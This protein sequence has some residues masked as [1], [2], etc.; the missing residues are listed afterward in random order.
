MKIQFQRLAQILSCSLVLMASRHA[1]RAAETLDASRVREIAAQLREQ[2]AGFAWPA[3]NRAAWLRLADNPA[4][5]NVIPD[6]VALLAKKLPEQP[7]SL[8]LEYS[9]NGNRTHWQD[10]ASER[11][12]RVAKLTLA[13]AFENR[14]RFLPALETTIAALCAEKTWV[15]PAH[16]GDLK[17][18]HGEATVPDLGATSLAAE[19][20][21]ADFVLGDK[22]SPATRQLLRENVR[23]RVLDPFRAM[24]EGRQPEAFWLRATMNWNAVCVGNTVF[25]ALTLLDSR[26][27]RAFFAA[28]GE[29]CIRF[30]LSG[31]TPDGYCPEG[32][33]YW[34]YGFGHFILLT[35]ILRQST[36]GRIDLLNDD[37]A[38]A[39]A[40]F[41]LRSEVLPGI[42]PTISDC[43]PG[44]KPSARFTAYVCRRFGLDAGSSQTAG[45]EKDLTLT[46][47]LSSLDQN[48]PL[49][50]K[51]ENPSDSPL[52]SFFP[53]GGVLI[54]RNVPGAKPAF[55]AVLKGGNN[56]EPHNHNDV[57]SFSVILGREMVLCD[58]GGEVYTKRTFGAHR[59]DSKVLNSFG[60]AVPVIAGELQKAG[61]DARG[62]ILET[63]F[64]ASADT[65]KLDIR[66]AY[67]V[68]ALK[69]LDR[70]FVFQRGETPSLEVRDEVT[71]STPEP[72]ETALVTWGTVKATGPN[73]LEIADG[74]STLRVTIDTQGRAFKWRQ[75]II[76]EDVQATR[77][78]VRIG[79]QLKSEIS[80][81]VI[82]MK[83]SPAG[84]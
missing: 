56:N 46:L 16:D 22:L 4:F 41:C 76:D 45:N 74:G 25:A 7:D 64:T 49:A 13:E 1:L 73:T 83:I 50:R 72:F 35:E 26:A 54:A 40:L 67:P 5:T 47:M 23:R 42:Y 71:F 51:L 82:T 81:G 18:F 37:L 3:S 77:K 27:D 70:T 28:A 62:V 21:E 68:P 61:A 65:F 14:G 19:L 24:V 55:A 58:P 17:N 11:R 63:N 39:P 36:G 43:S 80:S 29:H 48:L 15:L 59:Y 8:F 33:G 30:Y 60:H 34:N 66:Q 53:G 32:V 52:R 2:P 9:Q 31:F 75:E 84:K 20:A 44:S 69:K 78:P 12:G 6:A 57:G 10:V 38:V 79:I